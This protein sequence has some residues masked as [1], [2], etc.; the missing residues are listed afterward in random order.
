MGARFLSVKE[1]ERKKTRIMV[2]IGNSV[3]IYSVQYT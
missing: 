3:I 2:G 1:V